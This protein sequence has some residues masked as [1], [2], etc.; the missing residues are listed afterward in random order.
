ME[1]TIKLETTKNETKHW[2]QQWDEILAKLDK[3]H[4]QMAEDNLLIEQYGAQTQA[5]IER[6]GNRVELKAA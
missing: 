6:M 1:E 2:Q 4:E 3:I 5:I